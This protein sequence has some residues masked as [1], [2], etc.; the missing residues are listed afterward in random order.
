[1]TKPPPEF[2]R[3]EVIVCMVIAF[4]LGNATLSVIYTLIG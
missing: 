4:C 3:D 1:M 2:N